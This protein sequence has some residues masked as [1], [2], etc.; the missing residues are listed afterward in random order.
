MSRKTFSWLAG[1]IF[2]LVALLHLLRIYMGWAVTIDSW[3]VPTWV[4][5]VGVIVAGG[6]SY[7]GL[8]FPSRRAR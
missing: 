3:S 6:L 2:A 1:A 7:A 4:S 8:K 5:W